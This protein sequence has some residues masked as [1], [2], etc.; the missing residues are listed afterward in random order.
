MWDSL[1]KVTIPSMKQKCESHTD[2]FG[3]RKP[4]NYEHKQNKAHSIK[5]GN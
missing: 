3:M 4:Y 2:A 5:G 1:V